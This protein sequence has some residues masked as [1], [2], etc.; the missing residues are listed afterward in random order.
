[1][2]SL[3]RKIVEATR[4]YRF[5]LTLLTILAGPALLTM[6]FACNRY[7]T[8]P[9]REVMQPEVRSER[10]KPAVPAAKPVEPATAEPSHKIV[11]EVQNR[12]P[13]VEDYRVGPE[14]ILD[15]K[16][17]SHEDLSRLVQISQNGDFNYPLIGQVKAAG[18]SAAEIEKELSRRLADGYLVNPQVTVSIKEYK[19]QRVFVVGEVQ[20][21]GTFSLT[22]PTSVVEILSKAGGATQNAGTEVLIIRPRD[23]TRKDS[24]ATLE[25]AAADELIPLDLRAIQEGSVSPEQNI[26]LQHGDTVVV[27]KA[28]YFFV[29]GEVRKPDKYMH[30]PGITVLKAITIAGGITEK[31]AANR[32]TII[33][34]KDGVRVELRA[35]MNDLVSPNDIVMV[36]ESFF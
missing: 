5:R 23:H 7:P 17:W 19:S 35:K 12:A 33:R 27:P 14:D 8:V 24:P 29:F 16:V 31:A 9:E 13:V 26:I 6:L 3:R 30:E 18:K 10:V 21:P 4:G 34:E 15:I 11:A 32:T 25:E 22:G 2:K 1:M 36:P 20:N 28:K